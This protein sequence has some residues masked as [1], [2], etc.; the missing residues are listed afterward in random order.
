MYGQQGSGLANQ[1]QGLA[2][3][4]AAL[5]QM[6]QAYQGIGTYHDWSKGGKEYI[7]VDK[8][9]P[10]KANYVI[11]YVEDKK[12]PMIFVNTKKEVQKE[13]EKLAKRADVDTTSIRIFS[14][15]AVAKVQL[16]FAVATDNDKKGKK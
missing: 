4:Q 6:Q 1:L 5:Q 16:D 14:L 13:V 10:D 8:G 3:N 9:S 2:N 7:R 15:A 12:D 11:F